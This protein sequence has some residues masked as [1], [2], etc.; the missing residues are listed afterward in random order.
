MN[1]LLKLTS[2]TVL[3]SL[4]GCGV[5]DSDNDEPQPNTIPVAYNQSVSTVT[6]TALEGLL[7]GFDANG[8]PLSFA[9]DSEP[10]NGSV[11]VA[12]DGNFTYTPAAE[13]TG[14]DQF[15]FVINDGEV[16]STPATVSIT[17]D[18]KQETFSVYS[19]NVYQKQASDM[20]TGVNGR[21]FIDDVNNT[22]E[23]QDLVDSGSQ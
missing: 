13:F 3:L 1:T 9:L 4:T 10:A 14:D 17:V 21:T 19:R 20:P 22:D 2:A 15:T 11:T 18:I 8:D 23:Y 16:N 12:S 5:F 6:D 7:D